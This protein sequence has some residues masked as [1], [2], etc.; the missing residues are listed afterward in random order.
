MTS[1]A[2][3]RWP[4]APHTTKWWV[5]ARHRRPHQ[6][7]L[8]M[9]LVGH[10]GRSELTRPTTELT[11]PTTERRGLARIRGDR[12]PPITADWMIARTI[13]RAIARMIARM[14]ARRGRPRRTHARRWDTALGPPLRARRRL[15]KRPSQRRCKSMPADAPAA[16][17]RRTKLGLIKRAL[18]HQH[19]G[20][21]PLGH[22]R[23]FLPWRVC[24]LVRS[25][26][27]WWR[28]WT[29]RRMRG[30]VRPQN[31]IA[32]RPRRPRDCCRSRMRAERP[33]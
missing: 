17:R 4:V 12:L 26:R 7:R 27:R 9:V 24:R 30:W 11:R 14:I 8:A 33:C 15:A 32:P 5:A 6:R 23:G 31:C 1:P 3:H 20:H 21:Q 2:D 13:A 28:E 16:I 19:P 22:G 25:H 29:Q 10:G 18:A